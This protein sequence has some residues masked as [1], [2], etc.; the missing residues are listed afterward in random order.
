MFVFFSTCSY[1]PLGIEEKNNLIVY[2]KSLSPISSSCG[3]G[4]FVISLPTTAAFPITNKACCPWAAATLAVVA[5][6]FIAR[7]YHG[8]H[9][10]RLLCS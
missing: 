3:H 2:C 7:R 10:T 4:N 6:G 8:T 9:V 5:I 1:V